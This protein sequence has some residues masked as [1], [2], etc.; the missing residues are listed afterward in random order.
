MEQ[1]LKIRNK[2]SKLGAKE[3]SRMEKKIKM[4]TKFSNKKKHFNI[5]NKTSKV[6]T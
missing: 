6:E 1:T 3:I 5:G 2:T 4:G